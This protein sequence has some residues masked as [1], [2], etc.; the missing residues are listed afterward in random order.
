MNVLDV[1]RRAGAG[2]VPYPAPK[3]QR[4][5][6]DGRWQLESARRFYVKGKP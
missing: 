1:L 3:G 5:P 2:L 6:G 4:W